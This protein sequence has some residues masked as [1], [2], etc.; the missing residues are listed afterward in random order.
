MEGNEDVFVFAE[1]VVDEVKLLVADVEVA[2][3]ESDIT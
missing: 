2:S 1:D 3:K